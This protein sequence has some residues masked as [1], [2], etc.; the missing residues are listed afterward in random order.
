MKKIKLTDGTSL[1]CLRST[2]AIVLDDHIKG[3]FN[4]GI[5]LQEGDVIFDIGANIGV[6][7]VRASQTYNNIEIHSFE[8][9][10]QIYE[11]L[12]K[13]TELSNNKSFFAYQ[14]GLG[15][16]SDTISFT[17]F[18]NSPALST[19]NPELWED[20]PEAFKKAVKG[21]IKNSPDSF[22]WSK[23]IPGFVIPI[24]AWYLK[25]GEKKIDCKV[26]TLSEVIESKDI[27][28]INL[29]KMDC[30]GHEWE[31]VKGI[32]EEHW[33]KIQSIVMEVHDIDERVLK[34]E[35]LLKSKGFN[36]II[37]DKEKALEETD[38]VNI[39]ATR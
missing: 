1:Y 21:S 31:V 7:G 12:L 10:P 27:K 9:V 24:I 39:Y 30:E 36:N 35:K 32:K 13:N 28:T 17:Y 4:H 8:P 20:N 22:W 15:S 16:H 29:L 34:V 3:Y 11:V 23:L 18:P 14:M 5:S 33:P 19:S 6:F 38:L 26:C 37:K 25:K 2:E